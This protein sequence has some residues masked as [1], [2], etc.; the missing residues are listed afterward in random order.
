M[1]YPNHVHDVQF[2]D[3]VRLQRWIESEYHCDIV[4]WVDLGYDD[5]RGAYYTL[6]ASGSGEV[7]D[8]PRLKNKV[9]RS[10]YYEGDPRTLAHG[11]YSCLLQVKTTL[12]GIQE[13][14]TPAPT[15]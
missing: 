9:A 10:H 13:A 3:C 11:L 12:L 14:L 4:W 7:F 1:S 5:L 8:H 15:L 6:F 2:S